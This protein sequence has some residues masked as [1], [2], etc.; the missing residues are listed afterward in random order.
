MDSF[1]IRNSWSLAWGGV[2]CVIAFEMQGAGMVCVFR[3]NGSSEWNQQ[4]N[5]IHILCINSLTQIYWFVSNTNIKIS[6]RI[7]N[8]I[9]FVSWYHVLVYLQVRSQLF[10]QYIVRGS[11]WYANRWEV[12][13]HC[14]GKI[15]LR[16]PFLY[17]NSLPQIE[18]CASYTR[19]KLW[20]LLN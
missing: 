9:I 15:F 8:S 19:E 6:H 18:R 17:T 7:I 12:M 11:N 20:E 1:H 16:W 10:I 13:F 5:N 4:Q 14:M 3:S 2:S